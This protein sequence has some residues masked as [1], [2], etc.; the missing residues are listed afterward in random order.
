MNNIKAYKNIKFYT[1]WS[2]FDFYTEQ[3]FFGQS[4]TYKLLDK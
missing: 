1:Y 4:D 3:I 2:H